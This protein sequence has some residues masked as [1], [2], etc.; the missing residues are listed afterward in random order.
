MKVPNYGI[1]KQ[2]IIPKDK[3]TEYMILTFSIFLILGVWVIILYFSR[4][5]NQVRK[6]NTTNKN[7][8]STNA[9][10][11]NLS[12]YTPTYQYLLCKPNFCPTNIQTGEKRCSEF[13]SEQVPY[14]PIYEVCNPRNSCTNAA[15]P[16]AIQ[17][18]LSTDPLGICDTPGCRC[19]NYLQTP[20]YTQVLFNVS[21]GSIY[22]SNPQLL[23]SW[24]FNQ[25]P[26]T[27]IGQGNNVPIQYKGANDQFFNIAPSLLSRLSPNI[28]SDLFRDG[29][30]MG[31]AET[32]DCVNRNPC[33]N[34]KM[35]YLQGYNEFISN[36]D[37]YNDPTRKN[38]AC[39][40]AI[41]ENPPNPDKLNECLITQ[42][43]VFNYITGR[44]FCV[45][46]P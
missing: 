11:R 39:V 27:A 44:I 13:I 30:L 18:D 15:T 29:P 17:F 46:P 16:N 20:S 34:G 45:S 41:V 4:S 1:E 24:Y 23:N 38:L 36:F 22:T 35:A 6:A 28:C 31:T 21:G 19:V 25:I 42:A 37:Y 8:S 10:S 33:L 5:Y 40:P 14:D 43:P 9:N 2:Y 12:S 26:T 3:F 7:P 32:L